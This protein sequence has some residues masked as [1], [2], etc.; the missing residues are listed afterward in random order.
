MLC[1]RLARIQQEDLYV[2][3]YLDYLDQDFEFI[4]TD[5]TKKWFTIESTTTR[6]DLTDYVYKY[7][8]QYKLID[9]TDKDNRR[10]ALE[11]AHNNQER[12]RKLL[13]NIMEENISRWWD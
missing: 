3:E 11:I 4:P 8:R 7:R 2:Y 5:E 10:V 1:A 9:K 6:D 13:F 12:S